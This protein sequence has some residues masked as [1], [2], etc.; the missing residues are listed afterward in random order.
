MS[1][2]FIHYRGYGFWSCD[3][4]TQVVAGEAAEQLLASANA[5][6]WRL[7][8]GEKWRIQATSYFMGCMFLELDEFITTEE[9][10]RELCGVLGEIVRKRPHPDPVGRTA[11]LFIRLLNGEISWDASTPLDYMVDGPGR[12]EEPSALSDAAIFRQTANDS[13]NEQ[14]I[15]ED[16][17]E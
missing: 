7:Q 13:K 11:E 6:D 8:V 2:S 1:S 17:S 4:F 3:T 5:G 12:G 15:L 10:R 14:R 16:A 9:R